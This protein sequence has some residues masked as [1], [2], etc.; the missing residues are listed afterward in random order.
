MDRNFYGLTRNSTAAYSRVTQDMDSNLEELN[1][2]PEFSVAVPPNP[3]LVA[4]ME[5]E[6]VGAEKFRMLAARLQYLRKQRQLKK[7]VITSTL[8]GEGKS[9]ISANLALTLARRQRTLLIDGDL[10]QS[11]LRDLFGNHD[12]LGLTDWWEEAADITDF[13]RRVNELPLWY[14][15]PGEATG[16]PL[17]ILQS[18]R[19]SEM[20]TQVA[21]WFEWVIIDS[22]PLAA[23]ADP[24]VWAT[25]ADGTLLVVEQAK[26]PKKLLGKT[27]EGIENLKVIGVVVNGS[28]DTSHQYYRQYYKKPQK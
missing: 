1:P 12:L 27:L 28:Q 17:E 15:P 6:G 8:K 11:G 9:V 25:Q 22:P 4:M 23:V 13:L 7:L 16:E 20:L 3:R 21:E 24:N 10:R 5:K 14:L 18:Q 19:M 2:L 26:T